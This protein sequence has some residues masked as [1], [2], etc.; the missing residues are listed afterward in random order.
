M[1]KGLKVEG[2]DKLGKTIIFARNHRHA[3]EIVKVFNLLYPKYN[4]DFARVIDNQVNFASTVIET[5]EVPRET[6]TNCCFSRYVR[7]RY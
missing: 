3:E 1:E 4:G 7:Y 5:F 6:T 2:G